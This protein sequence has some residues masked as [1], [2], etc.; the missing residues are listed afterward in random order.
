MISLDGAALI[1]QVIP[2]GILIVALEVRHL[3]PLYGSNRTMTLLLRIAGAFTLGAVLLGAIAVSLCIT[4]VSSGTRL[5]S[6]QSV[7]VY[8][9][10]SLV[11]VVAFVFLA[12]LVMERVGLTDW[13]ARRK[14]SN[15]LRDP[16]TALPILEHIQ[17]TYPGAPDARS[18]I[19]T[20]RA[21]VEHK[22]ES[23]DAVKKEE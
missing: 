4:A 23:G 20:M 11:Y 14:L 9:G 5:D 10:G 6:W 13:A 1:A 7:V 19:A 8:V 17:R 15:V 18:V 12:L 2:I 3:E 21:E 22:D 16:L